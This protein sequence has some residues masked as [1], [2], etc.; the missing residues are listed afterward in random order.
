MRSMLLVLVLAGGLIISSASASEGLTA[1]TPPALT[2]QEIVQGKAISIASTGTWSEEP[3]SYT[4]QWQRCVYESECAAITGATSSTYTPVEGD[5]GYGIRVQ[6]TAH[7]GES[8][9]SANTG[10]TIGVE[11][12]Y[13]SL[14]AAGNWWNTKTESATADAQS[15]QQ[16]EEVR[17]PLARDS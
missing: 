16:V 7:K 8:T 4:Y 10:I 15:G 12:T 6:V 17:N 13:T 2:A 9:G 1:S 5:V 3:T 11:P 14:Y